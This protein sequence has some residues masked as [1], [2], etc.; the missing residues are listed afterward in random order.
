M[1]NY[2]QIIS[3][4]LTKLAELE[5]VVKQ[6]AAKIADLERHNGCMWHQLK[7]R[8]ITMYPPNEN[9]YSK[10]YQGQ[11]FMIT[12]KAI[13]IFSALN[14]DFVTNITCAN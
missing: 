13:T 3:T 5:H 6:Q 7:T 8:L 2:E 12:G 4:L 1:K 10:G 11:W 9:H 14:M